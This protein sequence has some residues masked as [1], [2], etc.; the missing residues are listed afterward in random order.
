MA[1]GALSLP[2]D[3]PWKRI[4]VS[5]DMIDPRPCDRTF[6]PR[7][8][9]SAAVFSY[10][11][12]DDY[13]TYDG[14]V[15]TY[16][17]VSFT[18]TGFQPAPEEVGLD[19]R[20]LESYWNDPEV[21]R[22]YLATAGRYYP[23]NGAILE[24]AVAPSDEEIDAGDIPLAEYPYIVDVEPKKREIYEAVSS[25]GEV[26]SRSL[27]SIDI[28]TG[29]TTTQSHEQVGILEGFSLN[30]AG[31]GEGPIGGG[32]GSIGLSTSGQWGNKDITQ[33]QTENTMTSDASREARE[34]TSHTTQLTQMYHQ[35]LSYHLGTNR[36]IFFLLPRPHIVQSEFTF[37]NG[38]QA[39]EGIQDVFLTVL[40]PRTTERLCVEAYLETAHIAR[41]APLQPR[42]TERTEILRV[43]DD[44]P[45]SR[46][47]QTTGRTY[48]AGSLATYRA[49]D[50]FAIYEA[51]IDPDPPLGTGEIA[52]TDYRIV[53]QDENQVTAWCRT[54]AEITKVTEETTDPRGKPTVKTGLSREPG[55]L[56]MSV[57][58]RQRKTELVPAGPV[59]TNL[60]ITGRGVCAC[61]EAPTEKPSLRESVTW[62]GGLRTDVA[63]PPEESAEMTV[64]DANRMGA[65]IGRQLIQSVQDRDR[66]P[67]GLVRFSDTEILA[68][69]V[70]DS[71]G[72][73]EHPDDVLVAS[74]Q[75][76][77]EA[78][79]N[80][81]GEV[82]PGLTRSGLLRM[83]LQEQADRLG[84]TL[85]RATE[86]RR[87]TLGLAVPAAEPGDRWPSLRGEP[88]IVPDLGGLPLDLATDLLVQS[89]LGLGMLSYAAS[90]LPA[91]YVVEQDP[92]GG[93]S[94][95]TGTTV[96]L[97]LGA[98]RP[99]LLPRIVGTSLVRALT[100]L[101]DAGV[102]AEPTLV[103]EP[104]GDRPAQRVVGVEPPE[105]TSVGPTSPIT[106]YVTASD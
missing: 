21:I 101:S 89:G 94:V 55:H 8:R 64:R 59:S 98:G 83:S 10:E 105:L 44:Q 19:N 42:V 74:I 86:V 28:R 102:E 60:W 1:V 97:V 67:A 17:K 15:I 50:G 48:S 2:I 18:V 31:Q 87:A 62:E 3:I 20:R 100:L 36:A 45:V 66:Y 93:A 81:L 80:R 24:V 49:R 7:W 32:G 104:R 88:R 23:C 33:R 53:S 72:G 84:L 6:P 103:F 63:A 92:D 40:R 73:G 9:S 46:T 91:D 34:N 35:F 37:V 16:V 65:D 56:E 26:M 29:N 11:P 96:R 70:A 95:P 76:L 38:P 13:Q 106:V 52:P 69:A 71:L 12:D 68:R 14:M 82:A 5:E 47:S 43:V 4:G 75:G 77:D 54:Y 61:A 79:A 90:D 25:S 99:V 30:L 41:E 78:V 22:N 39:L 58:V 57:R 51:V 85:E 27:S